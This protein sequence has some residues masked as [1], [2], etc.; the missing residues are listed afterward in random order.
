[1]SFQDGSNTKSD[2]VLQS[3]HFSSGEF[4]LAI[5]ERRRSVIRAHEDGK[6]AKQDSAVPETKPS[7]IV[8][9]SGTVR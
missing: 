4:V 8:D 9:E 7:Q 3:F 1:M 2:A 5:L 6:K